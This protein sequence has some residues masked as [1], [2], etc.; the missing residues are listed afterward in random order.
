VPENLKPVLVGVVAA[1]ESEGRRLHT[2]FFRR[3]GPRGREATAPIDTEIE[4]RL[5]DV[6]QALVPGTF[7]GEET[8][9]TPGVLEDWVW[10]VDPQDG[11]QEFLLGRRGSSVSVALLRGTVPVLG[12]VHCPLAPDRGHDTI[13]WAEG[14][15]PI[16]RN[17]Q[18]IAVDLSRRGLD[19]GEFVWT[20]ASSAFRPELFS[21][22][23][24]P[25]RYI[26]LPSIAYR[27]ARVAA[28]DGVA[29]LSTHAVNEY[30]IA[31][32]MAL[33]VAAG[34]VLLNAEGEEIVLQG[35]HEARVTGCFAGNRE[36]ALRLSRFEWSQVRKIPRR[37]ARLELPIA[38][39]NDEARLARAQGCL[40]GQVIGD[41][42]GSLVEFRGAAEIRR[43]YPQGVREL[44]DG[45]T[46]NTIAAQPTDDSEL[47]LTLARCL[48][49]E[50]KYDAAAVLERYRE[51]MASA[52]F[53]IGA[54]TRGGLLRQ[55]HPESQANGS[56]MRVS[57]LGVWATRDAE[58]AAALARE[59]SA[60]THPHA[61]C[62]EACAGYTAAIATAIAG[63]GR[64]AMIEK[65]VSSCS[66]PA[67]DAIRRGAAGER[68]PDN[69]TNA[70]WVLVALQNAFYQLVRAGS[71]EEALVDTVNA[72]GDTDTNAAIAGALLGA[73][74]G[75][76][77]IPRRWVL[78]VL[79][80]RPL[81]EAGAKRPRPMEYWPDDILELAEALLRLA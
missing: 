13:A 46:W 55:P 25:A 44:A 72:G 2:E 58:R 61:V 74:H 53:D 45:G 6:L 81:V 15:G 65:A 75:R 9:M 59:D 17:G 5:R 34:G 50:G 20:S 18:P 79:A 66:G 43:A 62:V 21:R 60:L 39:A 14:C 42:L 36:A 38:R 57:P 31:G 51:W 70:G 68:P 40:L 35:Q 67:Q 28:G 24:A 48:V 56:L 8:G 69:E 27:L 49:R 23:A 19:A 3:K 64:E 63:G 37:P 77:A 54:T 41:S 33:V 22:A 80:C 32:G 78:P 71:F 12:V 73:R 29:T 30:D 47:A 76:D 26:A 1:V 4:L 52:P 10:L 16:Q 7:L 11:T